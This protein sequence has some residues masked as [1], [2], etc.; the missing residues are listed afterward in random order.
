MSEQDDWLTGNNQLDE[1][2]MMD[3]SDLPVQQS[4]VKPASRRKSAPSKRNTSS[5]VKRKSGGTAKPSTQETGERND[6]EP[7]KQQN[8]D[9]P[10][11]NSDVPAQRFSSQPIEQ[12]DFT[13]VSQQN[14]QVEPVDLD[15]IDID[16]LL[17]DPWG[18]FDEAV[19]PVGQRNASPVER[20]TVESADRQAVAPGNV[21]D[22]ET[23]AQSPDDIDPFAMWDALSG[24]DSPTVEQSVKQNIPVEQYYAEPASQQN[25]MSEQQS[26]ADDIWA[27]PEPEP[28]QR[29]NGGTDGR[30]SNM[31]VQQ[32][33]ASPSQQQNGETAYQQSSDTDIW[34]DVISEP[35]HDESPIQ[36]Q[37][38]QQAN[39]QNV[40]TDIWED[41]DTG[42]QRT[43]E[44]ASRQ[45][46]EADIWD[47]ESAG[48]TAERQ[49]GVIAE[50]QN[51]EPDIWGS[52]DDNS[53]YNQNAAPVV[54]DD[55]WGDE[56]APHPSENIDSGA[57]EQFVASPVERNDGETSIQ[58]DSDFFQRNSI[59]SN[60]RT[61]PLQAQQGSVPQQVENDGVWEDTEPT[62][63]PAF[64]QDSE[65]GEQFAAYPSQQIGGELA[66]YADDIETGD[67]GDGDTSKV[68]RAIIL[69]VAVLFGIA[70]LSG[71]GYY[72][73]TTYT[74]AQA[75]KARQAEIQQ[76]H[77]LL[78]KA[79]NN[80]DK[81]VSEA[82]TLVKEIKSSLVKD[83]KAT[84]GE[85]DKLAKAAEGSPMTEDAIS[86]KLKALNT[87]YKATDTAYRKALE[88]KSKEVSD[89]L[90]S[91]I[92]QAGKLNDAPDSDDKKTMNS[93]VKRWKDKT[94]S[95]SNLSDANKAVSSLQS[96]VD[97]VSKA[98]TDAENAKKEEEEKKKAEEEAKQQQEAP[99]QAQQQQQSQQSQQ[100][101]TYTPQRQYT[102]TPQQQ[103][104]QQQ[105]QPQQQQSQSP[106]TGSDGNSGVMF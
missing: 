79:Q 46:G 20:Q 5:T 80:W 17:E 99:Q 32:F 90:K 84:L 52:G 19:E 74:H 73:Y 82:N 93:L 33:P 96:V 88:S 6:G 75:E 31:S 91:L 51:N 39:Q 69:I 105:S 8:A 67:D 28:S 68:V 100:Q 64:Q 7:A 85:C 87:Q 30:Q 3:M 25:G 86:R 63:P 70:L 36:R 57:G 45:S 38:M 101:Y 47:T 98:K 13:P 66:D 97:K 29:W 12:N 15:D 10:I 81:R 76:K 62:P 83:D 48:T 27:D 40:E 41:D 14:G 59:F 77:D 53:P 18:S 103:T 24:N 92:D 22:G 16:S 11:Q 49:N 104:Q 37:N 55:I 34:E 89:K 58:P 60:D 102:Y 106:S 9:T 54:Y 23:V 61:D 42:Q 71:G 50:Q 21:R 72:A 65:T 56:I 43:G 35:Q 2:L 95:T 26:A 78:T 44:T 1:S 94:V 4:D